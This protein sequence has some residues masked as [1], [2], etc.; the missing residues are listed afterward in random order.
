MIFFTYTLFIILSYMRRFVVGDQPDHLNLRVQSASL[1]VPSIV[2]VH[3]VNMQNAAQL[4][5]KQSEISSRAHYS[6][7]LSSY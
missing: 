6:R 7:L 1:H 2:T 5:A 4:A 3:R